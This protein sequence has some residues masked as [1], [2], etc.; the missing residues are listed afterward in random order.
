LQIT[1]RGNTALTFI[2]NSGVEVLYP[3]GGWFL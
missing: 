1:A 3:G 2:I